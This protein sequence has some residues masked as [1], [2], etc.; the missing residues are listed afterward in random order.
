MFKDFETLSP[1]ISKPLSFVE[2]R[3]VS[4]FRLGI[5]PIRI[6]TARYL[7]PVLPE[8]ERVCYCDS[9]DVESEY[10]VMF[11]CNKYNN[12]RDDWISHLTIADNFNELSAAEKFKLVLNEPGNIKNTARFLVALMDKRRL[13]NNFNW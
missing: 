6:E 1:H 12:L 4:K 10:H 5:L 13:L 11:V 2:R 7:R 9:G 8:I 3:T